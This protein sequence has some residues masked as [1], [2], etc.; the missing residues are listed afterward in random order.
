M[1]FS[2]FA[3]WIKNPFRKI[4]MYIITANVLIY[5]SIVKPEEKILS[6]FERKKT[7]DSSGKSKDMTLKRRNKRF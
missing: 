6:I 1:T 5:L 4:F 2:F 3:F 7:F